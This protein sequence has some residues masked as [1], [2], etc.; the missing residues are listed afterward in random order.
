MLLK[1][2]P[3]Y[4]WQRYTLLPDIP[5]LTNI[6]SGFDAAI[7]KFVYYH[8]EVWR[9][10]FP[11]IATAIYLVLHTLPGSYRLLD[12]SIKKWT[13]FSLPLNWARLLDQ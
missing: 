1:E 5:T 3:K 13:L 2:L 11:E 10:Y 7:L 4:L 6:S 12:R 9:S 8:S